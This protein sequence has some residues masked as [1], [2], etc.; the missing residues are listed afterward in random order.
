MCQCGSNVTPKPKGY[1]T[2]AQTVIRK[3]WEKSQTEEKP[4]TITKINKP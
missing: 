2:Q 4:V 1:I 3:I